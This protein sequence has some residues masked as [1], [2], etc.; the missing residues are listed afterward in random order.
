MDAD[1]GRFKNGVHFFKSLDRAEQIFNH[2]GSHAWCHYIVKVKNKNKCVC[3]KLS[4]PGSVFMV[5]A[6]S[7]LL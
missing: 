1:L 2:P 7:F 5:E 4:W 6:F 3:V